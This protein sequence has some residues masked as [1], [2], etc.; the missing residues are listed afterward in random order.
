LSIPSRAFFSSLLVTDAMTDVSA[1]AHENSLSRVFPRLGE[2]GT[3][4]AL[5]ALL[6][7]AI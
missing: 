3:T 5:M 2:V 6:E 4:E 7:M 1:E